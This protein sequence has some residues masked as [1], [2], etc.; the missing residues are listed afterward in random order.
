MGMISHGLAVGIGFALGN[1]D[2]RR[3]LTQLAQHPRARRARA[4]AADRLRAV[5]D[6]AT[7]TADG[8]G[9]G[10][11]PAA[12]P[13]PG[14]SV[15]RTVPAAP[16]AG[17]SSPALVSKLRERLRRG[18]GGESSTD[19]AVATAA[20]HTAAAADGVP[21]SSAPESPV[22]PVPPHRP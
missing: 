18:G 15:A 20:A 11:R 3:K 8:A 13:G 19:T 7:R 17:P 22:P 5:T 6:R 2:R 1:P 10:A 4:L 9:V 16:G 14:L 21:A 12:A